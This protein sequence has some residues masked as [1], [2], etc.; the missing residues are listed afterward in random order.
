L[1]ASLALGGVLGSLLFGVSA[2]DPFTYAAVGLTLTGVAALACYIPA[3]RAAVADP[4]R[5]LRHE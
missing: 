4:L 5:A 1:A 3:R 2:R